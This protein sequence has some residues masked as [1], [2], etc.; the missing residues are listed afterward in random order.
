MMDC[1]CNQHSEGGS[2]EAR[3]KFEVSLGYVMNAGTAEIVELDLAQKKNMMTLIN[4][5]Q[6]GPN[7]LWKFPVLSHFEL[8]CF[9]KTNFLSKK[10]CIHLKFIFS[11]TNQIQI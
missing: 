2:K 7:I 9:C 11:Y 6:Q 8:S 5:I 10:N 4:Q 1:E 3:D